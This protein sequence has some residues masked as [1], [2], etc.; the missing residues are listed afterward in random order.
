MYIAGL[1]ESEEL[2][3]DCGGDSTEDGLSR[4]EV[5]GS[6]L[7]EVRR[8]RGLKEGRN[9]LQVGEAGLRQ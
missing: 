2:S 1:T 3:L 5:W 6:F 8:R 4:V 9:A 7:C